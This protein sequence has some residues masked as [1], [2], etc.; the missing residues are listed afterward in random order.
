VRVVAAVVRRGERV[1]VCQRPAHKRHGGLWEFPGGKC[2]PG[3]SDVQALRRELQEELGLELRSAGTPEYEAHDE[4]SPFVIV[5]IPVV[6]TGEAVAHEH[7]ALR[8]ST[9]EQAAMLPLAP[10][11]RRYVH[12]RIAANGA[13]RES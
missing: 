13:E 4:G 3:E 8:W 9:L 11:D 5:F 7:A 10:S 1:L 12:Y 2:E 6:T